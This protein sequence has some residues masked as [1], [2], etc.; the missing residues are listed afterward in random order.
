MKERNDNMATF[1]NQD[2]TNYGL[3]LL[4][5]AMQ[6][7][8]IT[9]TKIQLGSGLLPTSKTPATMTALIEA[10]AT[11]AI[12]KCKKN[13]SNQ[14]VV[15]GVFSNEGIATSFYYRELGLWAKGDD[16]VEYLYCYGNA[17][18]N[19]ELIPAFTDEAVEKNI[20]IIVALASATNVTVEVDGN[21]ATQINAL[22]KQSNISSLKSAVSYNALTSGITAN[23]IA[24]TFEGATGYT[25]DAGMVLAERAQIEAYIGTID[26]T[27]D[28]TATETAITKGIVAVVAEV[29]EGAE[30]T[31]YATA[32]SSNW[33]EVQPDTPFTFTNSGTSIRVRAVIDQGDSGELIVLKGIGGSFE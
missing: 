17:G 15:G 24:C 16:G 27:T 6:S 1:I 26:V 25:V 30:L 20:D 12:S 4:M 19:A 5:K 7:D 8:S 31:V 11:V 2:L 23:A 32:D 29:P 28:A 33:Q 9:F 21:T 22:T 14:L 3:N 13:G 10:K 18:A